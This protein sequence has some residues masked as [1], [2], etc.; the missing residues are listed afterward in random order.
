VRAHASWLG[1]GG[2]RLDLRRLRGARGGGGGRR[3]RGARGLRRPASAVK[4]AS[5]QLSGSAA[6]STYCDR[7]RTLDVAELVGLGQA[8]APA[9]AEVV[10]LLQWLDAP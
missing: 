8:K 5:A 2:R 7:C 4:R 9:L 10:G 6:E 1:G 3:Q